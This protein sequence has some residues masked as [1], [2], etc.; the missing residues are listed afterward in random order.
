M[1]SKADNVIFE[2]AGARLTLFKNGNI[3]LEG[4]SV[5]I[6]GAPIEL[7]PGGAAASSAE[8]DSA[9]ASDAGGD[10]GAGGSGAEGGDGSFGGAG[11]SDSADTLESGEGIEADVSTLTA[12]TTGMAPGYNED[13]PNYTLKVI[14]NENSWTEDGDQQIHALPF[15][16]THAGLILIDNND[17]SKSILYDPNGSYQ[18]NEP[19]G[20]GDYFIGE[21]IGFNSDDYMKYQYEDGKNVQVHTFNISDKEAKRITDN[22]EEGCGGGMSCSKCTSQV[23]DGGDEAFKDLGLHRHP[24]ALGKQLRNIKKG[25]KNE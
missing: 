10:G 15:V 25:S 17:S 8:A 16:G 23:L 5:C 14:T 3:Q 13:K 2:T 22:I 18:G 21:G 9:P 20:T 4:K 24:Y 1:T 6:N 19:R 12:S 7:N 11:V